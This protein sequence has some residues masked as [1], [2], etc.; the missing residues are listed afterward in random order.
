M[1]LYYSL[2]LRVVKIIDLR[3]WDH[4]LVPVAYDQK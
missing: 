1:T 4:G 3:Q 2:S